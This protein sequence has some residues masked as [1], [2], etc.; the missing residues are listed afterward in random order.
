M[1]TIGDNYIMKTKLILIVLIFLSACTARVDQNSVRASVN[2]PTAAKVDKVEVGYDAKMP[3]IYLTIEPITV[4][5]AP[6]ETNVKLSYG[7]AEKEGTKDI[8]AE[9]KR[10]SLSVKYYQEYFLNRQRQ[11]TTQLASSLGGVGN[12]KLVDYDIAKEKNYTGINKEPNDLGIYLV[13]ASITEANDQVLYRQDK[14]RIPGIYK[15]KEVEVQGMVGLDIQ[16]I[17]PSTG[18]VVQA[19]PTQGSYTTKDVSVSGGF[20]ADFGSSREI[21]KSSIDQ[22]LRVALNN[23]ALDLHAKFSG[24][25]SYESEYE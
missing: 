25:G 15:D 20:I 12:F 9:K 4:K 16:V 18:E 14:S 3:K 19:F 6:R 5:I 23:A 13:R 22:A 21:V 10:L 7:E 2:I 8:I 1:Q 17:N 24:R 11:I